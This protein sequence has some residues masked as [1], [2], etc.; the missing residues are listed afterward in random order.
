MFC[1][2]LNDGEM[3]ILMLNQERFIR[4]VKTIHQCKNLI[5]QEKETLTSVLQQSIIFVQLLGKPDPNTIRI[6]IY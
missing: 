1:T 4:E 2:N 6:P 3:L 5:W